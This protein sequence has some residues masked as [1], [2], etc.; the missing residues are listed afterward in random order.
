MNIAMVCLSAM[1]FFAV[2]ALA[3]RWHQRQRLD[4]PNWGRWDELK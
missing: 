1:A 4:D 2:V 3:A